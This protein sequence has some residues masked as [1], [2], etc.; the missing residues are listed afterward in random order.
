MLI[1]RD[2]SHNTGA[3]RNQDRG[4]RGPLRLVVPL[5]FAM[6]RI[7]SEQ[8]FDFFLRIVLPRKR[9]EVEFPFPGL[10]TRR[11]QNSLTTVN[12]SEK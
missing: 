8:R 1:E 4:H 2:D 10:S 11:R 5:P 7:E 9:T 12:L 6:L 3:D